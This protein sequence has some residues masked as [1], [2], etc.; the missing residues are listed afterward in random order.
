MPGN[1]SLECLRCMVEAVLD[2]HIW[3]LP[4]YTPCWGCV[5][6]RCIALVSVTRNQT[7]GLACWWTCRE[8]TDGGC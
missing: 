8:V 4:G 3:A 5:H 7:V 6:G 1:G 2:E